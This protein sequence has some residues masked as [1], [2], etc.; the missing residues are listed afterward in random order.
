MVVY[1]F[2]KIQTV[3]PANNFV[4]IILTRTQR[5]TP[6][7]IHPTYAISRIRAFYMRKVKFTQQTCQEKLSQIIDDFP[8]LDDIHPF[9]ADLINILYDKDHYKLALGQINT[10]RA[11]VDNIAKDY[12]RM[13]KY[14]DTLY[15]CKQLKRA[16]LG[17]ICTLLKKNKSSLDYL[18]EVRKHLSRLPSIDP[19]T[20]TLLVTG[21]PNVGK[22]SFMNKVTRADVDVQPYAFTTKALYVGHMDYKYLRWQVIDTPGIL[23]HPLEQRNTIEMQA[24]TAL[25]HLQASVLFFL[26]ISEQ[27]GFTIE[28]Q[29]SLFANIRPLFANKPLLLVCNKIDQMPYELLPAHHKE[30]IEEAATTASAKIFTMSNHSEENVSTVKNYACDELLSHRV[31]T[32]VKGKKVGDVLNRLTVA[33]PVARDEIVRDISIP[34]SVL[35]ARDDPSSVAASRK[36]QKQKMVENGGAGVYAMDY[37]EHY[38]GMLKN[39]EWRHDVMPEI[40]NGKNLADFVDPDILA[41]LDEL[42][43]EEEALDAAAA[44]QDMEDDD[45]VSD[46][47]EE[48]KVTLR[49]I[50]DKKHVMIAEHRQAK[51]KNRSVLPRKH[52]RRTLDGFKDSLDSLGVDSSKLGHATAKAKKS[53]VDDEQRGRKRTRDEVED[54]DMEGGDDDDDSANK[55]GARLR[56]TSVARRSKSKSGRSLSRV[57]PRD[58]SGFRDEAMQAKSKNIA[59]KQQRKMNK[60]A[61]IGEADRHQLPKL[62]KWQNSGKRGNGNTNSR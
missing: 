61:K 14:G 54:V 28:Q 15:R 21:F 50:R 33:M 47:D 5:K 59:L 12:V 51:N 53:E 7:V 62:A 18:E 45:I 20:R 41:R 52:M 32:K 19:N 8:R 39:K 13:I 2:K 40:W 34:D 35:Q 29:L 23:D 44:D 55:G 1:N 60:M 27:C 4:D 6:T 57:A 24:V 25:A 42:E 26:D 36:T 30:A 56:S 37:T 11:L 16:A 38:E 46:L 43:R 17:R 31:S 49:A 22:S 10:A 58:E 48:D 9:Y 3:P